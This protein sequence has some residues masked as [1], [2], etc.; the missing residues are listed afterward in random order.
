MALIPVTP[1]ILKN[2]GRVASTPLNPEDLLLVWQNGAMVVVDA[3]DI[4]G[5]GGSQ[6]RQT[7]TITT[8][9]LAP[10]TSAVGTITLGK[11]YRL[12]TIETTAPCRVRIYTNA[13]D[14]DA[15]LNRQFGVDRPQ[16][17]GLMLEFVSTANLLTADLSPTVDGF[18]A[19]GAA[20]YSVTNRGLSA[21]AVTVEFNYL[22]TEV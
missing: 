13:A 20:Y 4:G 1:Q 6:S 14:R 3:S 9:S 17:V 19:A 12:L 15:D 16:G 8:A 22:P 21:T 18:T 5:G 7:A 10:N 11:G 2:A